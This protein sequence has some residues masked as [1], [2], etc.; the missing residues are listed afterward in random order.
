MDLGF[1]KRRAYALVDRRC[2]AWK[3]AN[4]DTP[5]FTESEYQSLQSGVGVDLSV[6]A[7]SVVSFADIFADLSA[8]QPEIVHGVVHAAS[9]STKKVASFSDVIFELAE[10]YEKNGDTPASWQGTLNRLQGYV[11]EHLHVNQRIKQGVDA[12][13]AALAN[14]PGPDAFEGVEGYGIKTTKSPGSIREALEKY[15]DLPQVTSPEA[16]AYFPND[17][18]VIESS[19][20]ADPDAIRSSIH[21]AATASHDLAHVNPF[22]DVE[23]PVITAILCCGRETAMLLNGEKEFGEAASDALVSSASIGGGII[24]GGK[25]GGAVDI[26]LGGMG[27]G[28]PTL[29][30]TLAGGVAGRSFFSHWRERHLRR[31][32]SS[33]HDALVK[34]GRQCNYHWDHIHG[35]LE[36]TVELYK[37]R[38]ESMYSAALRRYAVMEIQGQLRI[39][40]DPLLNLLVASASVLEQRKMFMEHQNEQLEYARYRVYYRS[41]PSEGE[42]NSRFAERAGLLSYSRESLL[43]RGIPS[44][45]TTCRSIRHRLTLVHEE[46]GQFGS[47]S[48]QKDCLCPC[49]ESD[50]IALAA[51]ELC[52]CA[53]CGFSFE[54]MECGTV[55]YHT[56]VECGFCGEE[57]ISHLSPEETSCPTCGEGEDLWHD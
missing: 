53:V 25:I 35:N 8:I 12:K 18:R 57:F 17:P 27:F 7:G 3:M 51:G 37:S 45:A 16:K 34:L 28:V 2:S 9:R 1:S 55:R 22:D 38:I 36:H 15:P 39:K 6:V 41:G 11:G 4:C 46:L 21:E 50:S 26:A 23:I 30:C 19:V 52:S 10:K 54:L 47:N 40:K 29:I 56:E 20:L 48:N 14:N 31:A 32:Q 43:F 24:A 13:L 49:G 33:L 44:A 42:L 5:L